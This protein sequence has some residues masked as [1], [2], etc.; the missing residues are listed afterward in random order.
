[1]QYHRTIRQLPHLIFVPRQMLL[2]T[3]TSKFYS[4]PAKIGSVMNSIKC[5][6][7]KKFKRGE[8]L[9]DHRRDSPKHQGFRANSSQPGMEPLVSRTGRIP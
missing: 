4:R 3:T 6:C 8:A 1:M 7:G 5:E 2:G 9:A